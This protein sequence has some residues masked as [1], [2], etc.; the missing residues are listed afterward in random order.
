MQHLHIFHVVDAMLL[1]DGVADGGIVRDACQKPGEVEKLEF[2]IPFYCFFSFCQL[3][4][5]SFSYDKISPS[6][7]VIQTLHAN[8]S[9]ILAHFLRKESEEIHQIF[10]SSVKTFAQFFVLCCHAHGTGVL[11]AFAHHDATQHNQRTGGKTEFLGSQHCH[12]YDVTACFQ[13][14]VHL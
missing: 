5:L 6:D 10:A 8:F 4:P 2:R 11:M 3:I 7:D 13:L 14:P 1:V 12:Q 9:Q